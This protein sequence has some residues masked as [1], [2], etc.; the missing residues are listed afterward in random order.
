M[1]QTK[2]DGFETRVAG[3]LVPLFALRGNGDL[4]CGDAGALREFVQWAADRGFR[5]VQLLPVNETGADN[6]PY[7]AISSVAIEPATIHFASVGDLMPAEVEAL[8]GHHRVGEL[9]QGPVKWHAVKALKRELLRR[10]FAN[11]TGRSLGA[12][13]SHVRG[14]RTFIEQEAAWIESYAFYRVLM[15]MHGTERW[16]EWP[17]EVRSLAAA[18]AWLAQQSEEKRAEFAQEMRFFQ[19]VQWLAFSQ[20][21]EVK[22]FAGTRDVQLMGDVP[23]GVNYYSADVWAQPE[24]FDLRWSGGAPPEPA[25]LDDAFVQKWGQ[26]WGVPLYRW[27]R[28]RAT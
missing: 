20:W 9:R 8:A 4:G 16:D 6:S 12:N 11:F 23:F 19:Y 18:R 5:L 27:P 24:L 7:N 2:T 17:A 14:F 28:H 15:E 1:Q 3:V 21:R 25:F 10:A 13:E 26:N 22:A